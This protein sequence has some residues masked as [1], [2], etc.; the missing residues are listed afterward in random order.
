M[1]RLGRDPQELA[2]LQVDR[3][4]DSEAGIAVEALVWCHQDKPY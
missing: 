1:L 2:G 3:H 4:L